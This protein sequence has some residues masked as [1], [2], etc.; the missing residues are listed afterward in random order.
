M[1]PPPPR[2]A[3]GPGIGARHDAAKQTSRKGERWKVLA[4][5]TLRTAP[6]T[7]SKSTK[8]KPE[9]TFGPGDFVE[10]DAT[11]VAKIKGVD[12]AFLRLADGSG[13]LYDREPSTG[14]TALM[15][16]VL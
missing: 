13:W 6:G 10:V 15:R 5:V 3:V 2:P 7:F 1:P 16:R 11:E 8:K 14:K 12:V 9:K 4:R